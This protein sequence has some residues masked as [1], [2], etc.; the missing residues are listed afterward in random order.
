V[1]VSQ[2]NRNLNRTVVNRIFQQYSD[3]ITPHQL[4]HF[5]CT[6]AI[7][8]GLGIH[9]VANQAGH[10]NINTTLLYTNPDKDKLKRKMELL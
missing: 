3:K 9:E 1:F 6:N 8:K 7:E 2:K 10:S 4:R 5:F